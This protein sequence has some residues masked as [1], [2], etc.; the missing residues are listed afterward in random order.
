[1]G[2]MD[3]ES[4]KKNSL[5]DSK[6]EKKLAR[7]STFEMSRA[8]PNEKDITSLISINQLDYTYPANLSVV[9]QRSNIRIPSDLGSYSKNGTIRFDIQTGVNFIDFRNSVLNL[10]VVSSGHNA[11]LG[12]GSAM[13][14]IRSI[15]VMSRSG[16]ELSRIDGLNLLS[17][18]LLPFNSYQYLATIGAA[19]GYSLTVDYTTTTSAN[20]GF[21]G[22]AASRIFVVPMAWLSGFFDSPKLCP[23]VLASGLQIQIQLEDVA[24]A[25][26]GADG[27]HVP[28]DYTITRPSLDLDCFML[29]DAVLREINVTS[30]KSGLE[31]TYADWATQTNDLSVTDTA[32]IDVRCSVSR[33]LGAF[34]V[35]RAAAKY[36]GDAVGY[37]DSFIS[38]ESALGVFP[39]DQFQWRLGS[40]F[41]PY[42]IATNS[43]NTDTGCLDFYVRMMQ[44]VGRFINPQTEAVVTPVSFKGA[45]S[46]CDWIITANLERSSI[47]QLAGVPINSS[48]TLNL[49]LKFHA[50]ATRRVD[51]FLRYI[52][53]AKAYLNQVIVRM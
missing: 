25:L 39:V 26:V 13:N 28:T 35:S 1:M 4:M 30:A 6:L 50:G 31:Y 49:Y 11:F 17:A 14:F 51:T 9:T 20:P 52:K 34:A 24:T 37:S 43:G 42:Q 27:T 22:T 15:T 33:A 36:T 8:D 10:P 23:S 38:E 47:I 29:N 7:I 19:A 41:F 5:A 45:A 48:R 53:C 3:I 44:D 40:S 18:K 2:D 32:N 16:V 46:R 12:S 21:I